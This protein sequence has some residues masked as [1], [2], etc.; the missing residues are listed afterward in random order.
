MELV[1]SNV[2]KIVKFWYHIPFIYRDTQKIHKYPRKSPAWVM[3]LY[4]PMPPV[5]P[6]P[7]SSS[8]QEAF[9][10]LMMPPKRSCS[11]R[12]LQD[13]HGHP[14]ATVQMWKTKK[15]MFMNNKLKQPRNKTLHI[16]PKNKQQCPIFTSACLERL[17]LPS[18][19]RLHASLSSSSPTA[20]LPTIPNPRRTS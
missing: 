3:H 4:L 12:F 2:V 17:F 14:S 15:N 20:L 11:L 5:G 1:S 6:G 16:C 9:E 18:P 10:F 8:Q 13:P 19:G 7:C